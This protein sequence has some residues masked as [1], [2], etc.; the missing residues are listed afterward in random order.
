VHAQLEGAQ[1]SHRYRPTRIHSESLS[2]PIECSFLTEDES[3]HTTANVIDVSATGL[4]LEPTAAVNGATRGT[5]VTQLVVTHG[6]ERLF[7]GEGVVVYQTRDRIGVRTDG[8]IDLRYVQV[9]E[10]VEGRGLLQSLASLRQEFSALKPEWRAAVSDLAS[11]LQNIRASLDEIEADLIDSQL[12]HP[13]AQGRF[14]RDLV[15]EWSEAHLDKIRE[16]FWLSKELDDDQIELGRAYAERLLTPLYM[17]GALYRRAITKPRGYAGDYL[18]M[19]LFNQ[20]EPEGNSLFEKFVDLASKQHSL[21]TTALTRQMKI[22][23]GVLECILRGGERIV[24]V[25]SGPAVELGAVV[26]RLRRDGH[27]VEFILI[28]QDEEALAYSH[29]FLLRRIL[30]RGLDPFKV[31]VNCIHFSVKQILKPRNAEELQI[32]DH[33]LGDS[34]YIYSVGLL[35]YLP[36]PIAARL[37]A[38]LYERLAPGGQLVIGNLVEADDA[39]WLMDFVLAWHLVWRTPSAMAELARGLSPDP[40]R[41]DVSVDATQKC[42]FLEVHAP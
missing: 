27:P 41:V 5:K 7:D 36:D 26:D 13:E 1:N 14:L 25:A 37:I 34:D 19:L 33:V 42:L 22:T 12:G 20:K 38:A 6:D 29:D 9:R 30:D 18:T 16:L 17:H 11:L 21:C 2:N 10:A 8:L 28:D 31:R 24:S 23:E 35:D 32:L 4:A 15:D 39:T 40:R 3:E